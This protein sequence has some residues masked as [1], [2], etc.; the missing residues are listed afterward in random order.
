MTPPTWDD[1]ERVIVGADH[2]PLVSLLATLDEPARKTLVKPM[3]AY[4]RSGEWDMAPRHSEAGLSLVG[5]AV[6]PDTKST[7]AWLRRFPPLRWDMWSVAGRRPGNVQAVV[8]VLVQ[9]NPTWLPALVQVLAERLATGGADGFDLVD[10]LRLALGYAPPAVPG[11]IA[12]WIQE[13]WSPWDGRKGVIALRAEPAIARLLPLAVDDDR[14]AGLLRGAP[15]F[16]QAVDEGLVDRAE[17]L[18]A[19]LARLQR[20]GR[21]QATNDFVAVLAALSPTVGEVGDRIADYLALLPPGSSSTVAGAAQAALIEAHKAGFVSD[22]DLLGASSMLLA[23]DEKKVLRAQVGWLEHHARE[24]PEAREAIVAAARVA[25]TSKAVDVQQRASAL[26]AELGGAVTSPAAPAAVVAAVAPPGPKPVTPIQGLDE[27]VE[28]LLVNLRSEANDRIGLDL[29]RLVEALPRLAGPGGASLRAVRHRFAEDNTYAWYLKPHY[30]DELNV[31]R[32]VVALAAALSGDDWSDPGESFARNEGP[33]EKAL[34]LRIID[35]ARA[36]RSDPR[37]RAV[38]LPTDD[39]GRLVPEV[40][41]NRLAQARAEGWEPAPRDLELAQLRSGAMP[42]VEPALDVTVV[43]VSHNDPNWPEWEAPRPDR[44]VT[45]IN[46]SPGQGAE[47]RSGSL[48]SLLVSRG[49]STARGDG[50]WS[51]ETHFAAWPLVLP[52]HPN[53]IAAHLVPELARAA[54]SRS[55]GLGALLQLA[56]APADGGEAVEL[57]LANVL[58]GS[59][60]EARATAVDALVALVGHARLDGARLGRRLAAMVLQ[61]EVT[62]KRLP[63]PLLDAAAAGG[64]GEI[65]HVLHQLLSDLLASGATVTG[66]VDLLT[67]AISVADLAVDPQGI[68][69][70]D[71]LAGRKSRSGQVLE[72]KRLAARLHIPVRAR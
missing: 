7:A 20:G 37:V 71:E 2:G 55:Q 40:L 31:R 70:L 54:T 12:L 41:E 19:L 69:G 46:V 3:R 21:P 28:L 23:R 47:E 26:V 67:C 34:A 68:P 64:A 44:K 38:S 57:A 16:V 65:W 42:K 48:W 22:S 14:T 30:R 8:A 56:E 1:I 17:V 9:R 15:E 51:P 13:R 33:P 6:L 27:A 11:F 58:N 43:T 4:S 5:A 63:G 53:V 66:M 39:S 59:S 45:R 49:E 29:E 25:L 72:A 18:D 32:S 62:P 10:G 50:W 52:H 61:G 35:L 36:V 24:H 60:A